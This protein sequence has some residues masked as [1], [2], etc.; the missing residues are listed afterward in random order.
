MPDWATE[1]LT[2]CVC[3]GI[4]NQNKS[5][6]EQN[7]FKISLDANSTEIFFCEDT[8]FYWLWLTPLFFFFW[9]SHLKILVG[10]V[11]I[12]IQKSCCSFKFWCCKV[13]FMAFCHFTLILCFGVVWFFFFGKGLSI[14]L[15]SEGS[16]GVKRTENMLKISKCD[17]EISF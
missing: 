6:Q 9:V 3:D 16:K 2:H 15:L 7:N 11:L 17:R 14:S 1:K 10:L 4:T 8:R 5:P 12:S 13:A